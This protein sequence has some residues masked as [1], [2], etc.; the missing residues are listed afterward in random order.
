[1]STPA[2]VAAIIGGIRKA[3][4]HIGASS[5]EAL[6]HI[7][8]GADCTAELL[9]KMQITPTGLT[10]SV[11]MLTGRGCIGRDTRKTRLRLVY[12]RKHPDRRGTQLMLTE[13]GKALLSSTFALD[14]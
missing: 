12:R 11:N 10:K 1:M 7:A 6:F 9:Q 8:G 2:E 5:I 3:Q 13:E 4:P 14:P